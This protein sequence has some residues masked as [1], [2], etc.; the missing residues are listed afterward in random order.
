M[1]LGAKTIFKA[2]TPYAENSLELENGL[3]V[4]LFSKYLPLPCLY[5]LDTV[6]MVHQYPNYF[7][8]HNLKHYYKGINI[9]YIN[10]QHTDSTNLRKDP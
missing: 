9:Y 7:K 1:G 8:D 5:I 10:V 6:T 3:V 4:N 2:Q